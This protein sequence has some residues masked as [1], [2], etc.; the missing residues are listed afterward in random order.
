MVTVSGEPFT[1]F[2][3]TSRRQTLFNKKSSIGQNISAQKKILLLQRSYLE[4]WILN[5]HLIKKLL[6][7]PSASYRQQSAL[8]ILYFQ[9]DLSASVVLQLLL[10]L[11]SPIFTVFTSSPYFVFIMILYFK[12]R[13]SCQPCLNSIVCL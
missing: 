1:S 9:L 5:T 8:I 10:S 2:S 6:M 12:F 11:P 13:Y 7:L 4:N 3:F